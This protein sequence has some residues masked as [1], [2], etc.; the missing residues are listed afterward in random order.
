MFRQVIILVALAAAASSTPVD[1]LDIESRLIGGSNAALGRFP[2]IAA[3]MGASNQFWCGCAIINNR[4]VLT[5]ALMLC[6]WCSSER[7]ENQSRF[8]S[9]S[10]RWNHS[11][12]LKTRRPSKLRSKDPS[13]RHWSDSDSDR[14][15]IQ[16]ECS[17]DRFHL[18]VNISGNLKPL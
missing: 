3:L 18:F 16:L 9:A 11:L 2:Y 15:C 10:Q 13:C 12:Q 8:S 4:W 1:Y 5:A 17:A 6:S 14:Y 7:I